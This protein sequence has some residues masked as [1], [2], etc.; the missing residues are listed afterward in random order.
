L[1]NPEEF[2]A[3]MKLLPQLVWEKADLANKIVDY[4]A[5][6][7]PY[8]FSIVLDFL[9]PA[10]PRY[11][12]R[13]IEILSPG[14]LV[15]ELVSEFEYSIETEPGKRLDEMYQYLLQSCQDAERQQAI[16]RRKQWKEWLFYI[17]DEML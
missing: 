1:N 8:L 11:H 4:Y 6:K 5:V 15:G 16:E 10:R 13:V 2:E 7:F 14:C 12:V 17:R 3:V 9:E